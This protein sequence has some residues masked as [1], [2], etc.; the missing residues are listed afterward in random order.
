MN[1][2]RKSA[3]LVLPLAAVLIAAAPAPEAPAPRCEDVT[4]I[5]TATMAEDGTIT[6]RLRSLPPGPIGEGV[7][8]YTP[9]DANYRD[10]LAH[11][12]GGIKAG[13]TKPIR[14]WC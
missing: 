6:L 13:E 9:N 5:G 10:V 14:P 7:F 12:E 3:V 1:T 8:R 2:Q 4:S 11:I